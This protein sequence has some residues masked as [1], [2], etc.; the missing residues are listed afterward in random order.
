MHGVVR[1]ITKGRMLLRRHSRQLFT[2]PRA[3]WQGE[4]GPTCHRRF[5][6]I[7][8]SIA[9]SSVQAP[10]PLLE[11]TPQL[12]TTKE[13]P[14]RIVIDCGFTRSMNSCEQSSLARQIA[15]SY[16]AVR[17]CERPA[18]LYLSRVRDGHDTWQKGLPLDL[19]PDGAGRSHV[20]TKPPWEIFPRE[21]LV[22]LSPDSDNLLQDV[23]SDHI[24]VF[25]GIVDIC[26]EPLKS[27]NFAEEHGIVHATLP[28]VNAVKTNFHKVLTI[29]QAVQIVLNFAESGDWKEAVVKNVP[30]DKYLGPVKGLKT[31]KGIRAYAG[32]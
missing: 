21:K 13:S 8:G 4:N 15:H 25:G 32:D 6:G 28:V 27:R 19:A 23:D 14:I 17:T 2:L 5:T 29:N 3:I 22:F 10:L 12:T 24:Y 20:S 7:A 16:Y 30:H 31:R 18:S 26:V 1:V 9:E 11:D